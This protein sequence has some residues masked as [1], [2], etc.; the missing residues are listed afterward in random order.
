[1]EDDTEIENTTG[2]AKCGCPEQIVSQKDCNTIFSG[3]SHEEEY[4]PM[5]AR[6]EPEAFFGIPLK[7]VQLRVPSVHRSIIAESHGVIQR[8]ISS[9][10]SSGGDASNSDHDDMNSDS[11]MTIFGSNPTHSH[12]TNPAMSPP[13][14]S[15]LAWCRPAKDIAELK[16]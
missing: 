16:V 1:L 13:Q 4:F 8:Q 7:E 3:L 9:E 15:R 11:S 12:C 6:T 10:S 5:V 2:I 14:S